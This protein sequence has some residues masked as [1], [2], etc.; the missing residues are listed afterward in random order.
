MQTRHSLDGKR[1]EESAVQGHLDGLRA[2]YATAIGSEVA[3][4]GDCRTLDIRPS[5]CAA[6]FQS[7]VMQGGLAPAGVLADFL[8]VETRT[9]ASSK[10]FCAT[11]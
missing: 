1:S 10:T 11:N 9:R 3:R 5:R 2:E 7:G 6:L 8:E 4:G